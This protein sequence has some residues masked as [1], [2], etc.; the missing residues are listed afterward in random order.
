[1]LFFSEKYF[2][3]LLNFHGQDF[4]FVLYR[5]QI[6]NLL[7]INYF[8]RSCSSCLNFNY[9]IN[10]IIIFYRSH[11]LFHF[12]LASWM[13]PE[14]QYSTQKLCLSL[15][16]YL[17]LL[18]L[19][20]FRLKSLKLNFNLKKYYLQEQQAIKRIKE[21]KEMTWKRKKNPKILTIFNWIK[22]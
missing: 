16:N 18:R 12:L 7:W 13:I 6:K 19:Q 22:L 14:L 9:K 2:R 1:M 21:S 4:C 8:L 5:L 11:F 10:N 15:K 3:D 20:Q 17:K